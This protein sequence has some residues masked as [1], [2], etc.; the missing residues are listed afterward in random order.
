MENRL[1][2]GWGLASVNPPPPPL[3]PVVY[4]RPKDLPVLLRVKFPHNLK[5]ILPYSRRF[6]HT[7]VMLTF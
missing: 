2:G 5:F 7:K 3:S 1:G 6:I 4:I